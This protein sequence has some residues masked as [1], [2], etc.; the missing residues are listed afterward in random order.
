MPSTPDGFCRAVAINY[1]HFTAPKR[2]G[3]WAVS[4][5]NQCALH[6]S[7][8]SH[9]VVLS[10]YVRDLHHS[11]LIQLHLFGLLETMRRYDSQAKYA[12]IG[13]YG[14]QITMLRLDMGGAAFVTTFKGHTGTKTPMLS[15]QT[16]FN[17]RHSFQP[18]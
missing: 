11:F 13:D 4:H 18:Q 2:D 7:E 14:G 15:F 6:Y 1:F 5:S 16:E 8:F 10:P 9:E 12:F 17:E 3:D